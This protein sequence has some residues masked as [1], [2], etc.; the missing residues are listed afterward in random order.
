MDPAIK[1]KQYTM[2]FLT[3]LILTQLVSQGILTK[4]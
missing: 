3:E 4:N 1:T 2:F